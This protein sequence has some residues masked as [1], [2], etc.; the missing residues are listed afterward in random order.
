SHV[1]IERGACGESKRRAQG[2]AGSRSACDQSGQSRT[3]HR[4]VNQSGQLLRRAIE[5]GSRNVRHAPSRRGHGR[6]GESVR[7]RRAGRISPRRS[8]EGGQRIKVGQRAEGI[9]ARVEK[10]EEVS[11]LAK[12]RFL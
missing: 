7:R 1:A 6:I 4:V 5:K 9:Q 12:L 8:Q 10:G 11:A 3:P 2:R